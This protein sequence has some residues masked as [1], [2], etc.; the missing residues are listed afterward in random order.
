MA[1]RCPEPREIALDRLG[2]PCSYRGPSGQQAGQRQRHSRMRRPD[3]LLLAAKM[4]EG[5]RE[6][7]DVRGF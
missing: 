3:P 6:P 1:S 7:R 4:K 2:D 5:S